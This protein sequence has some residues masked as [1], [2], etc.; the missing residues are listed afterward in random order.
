[1]AVFATPEVL[2]TL[3]SGSSSLSSPMAWGMFLDWSRSLCEKKATCHC[4]GKHL[5]FVA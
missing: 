4:P 1:M 5:Q 3:E 2:S